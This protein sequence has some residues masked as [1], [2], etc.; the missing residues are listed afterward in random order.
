[1]YLRPWELR[2]SGVGVL[3]R[4]MKKEAE[5]SMM[6]ENKEEARHARKQTPG[7]DLGPPEVIPSL[8]GT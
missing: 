7:K 3:R 6:S 2:V 5:V 8:R 4:D 1:M